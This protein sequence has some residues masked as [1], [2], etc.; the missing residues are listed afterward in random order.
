MTL[1]SHTGIKL[2]I[3]ATFYPEIQ[4]P[5]ISRWTNRQQ[6]ITSSIEKLILASER[7]GT[8]PETPEHKPGY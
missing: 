6:Q 5:Q 7:E 4:R 8:T 3:E 1:V 2:K